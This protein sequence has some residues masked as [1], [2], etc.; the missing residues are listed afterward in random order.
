MSWLPKLTSEATPISPFRVIH[1]LN[2]ALDGTRAMVTHDSGNPR[3][4][5]LTAF[6]ASD[7]ARAI[8]VGQG[9]RGSAPDWELHS[10]QSLRALTIRW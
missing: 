6:E 2:Q 9:R 7:S 8:W 10:V 1:E 3:D 5:L 4:Q